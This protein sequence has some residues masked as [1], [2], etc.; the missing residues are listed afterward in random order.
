MPKLR[1]SYF[2]IHGGRGEPARLALTLG[3]IPFEDHRIPMAEFMS[4]REAFPLRAVPVLE[5]D[6]VAITQSNTICRYVGRLAGLYPDTPLAAAHCDEVLDIVE[7][8]LARIVATV[9]AVTGPDT[10]ALLR[11]IS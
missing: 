1:L 2:D 4:A 6:G 3:K 9:D 7:D 10:L 11:M 5:V 8:L